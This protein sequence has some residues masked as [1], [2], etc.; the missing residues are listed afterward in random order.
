MTRRAALI[1]VVSFVLFVI[2]SSPA[3][4]STW[5]KPFQTASHKTP[6]PEHQPTSGY[7]S[8]SSGGGGAASASYVA[9]CSQQTQNPHFS[10]STYNDLTVTVI[11]CQFV[12]DDIKT[13]TNLWYNNGYSGWQVVAQGGVFDAQ[14]TTTESSYVNYICGPQGSFQGEGFGTV[15]PG[16]GAQPPSESETSWSYVVTTPC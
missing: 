9:A 1:G 6:S 2:M 3:T 4:A 10:T 8:F 15:T 12:A 11:Q 16:H 14:Y 7:Y 5:T 13:W